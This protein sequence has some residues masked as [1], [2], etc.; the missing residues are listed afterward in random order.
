MLLMLWINFEPVP[1][2]N[3]ETVLWVLGT[4]GYFALMFILGLVAIYYL[5]KWFG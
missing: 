5:D 4:I 1:E 3:S 2:T